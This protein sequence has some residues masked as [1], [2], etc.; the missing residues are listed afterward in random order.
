MAPSSIISNLNSDYFAASSALLP[1]NAPPRVLVYVESEED[2]AFWRDILHPFEAGKF[3]FEINLPSA[4]TLEKGK[5][6]VLKLKNNVGKHFILCVDSDYDYLLQQRTT[7]SSVINSS[8]YIFQTYA[9]AIEN[10]RC[11]SQSL[12]LVCTQSVKSDK[13]NIDFDELLQKY[14][15]VIYDLLIWSLAFEINGDKHSLTF[16]T[17]TQLIGVSGRVNVNQ[18]GATQL[19]KIQ[20]AAEAAVAQFEL[21]HPNILSQ[22]GS[23]KVALAELG[24]QKDNAYLFIQGHILEDNFVLPFL[25]SQT[26][27]IQSNEEDKIGRKA[28][29][30]T[31]KAG[32]LNKYRNG[33]VPV[34]TCLKLNT[35]YKSCFLS[36]KIHQDLTEYQREFLQN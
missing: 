21:N 16:S 5:A 4:T 2:I 8:P 30:G 29:H 13:L 23:L 14:S 28:A 24:L 35:A 32:E 9:Y 7:T 12:R 36:Q 11:Y 10:L 25:Q 26:R 34:E 22:I 3:K 33:L 19:E 6:S 27:T 20:R 31:Q 1:Q 17:M 18:Q 15:Q